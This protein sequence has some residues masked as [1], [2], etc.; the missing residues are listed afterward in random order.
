MKL[1]AATLMAAEMRAFMA[2]QHADQEWL[3]W[4]R[5]AVHRGVQCDT[6]QALRKLVRLIEVAPG[7]IVVR[8]GESE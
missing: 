2:E 6:P 8:E 4:S 3:E 5:L 7:V 1:S